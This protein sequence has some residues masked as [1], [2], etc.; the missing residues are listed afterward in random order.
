MK[1]VS[2]LLFLFITITYA[3]IHFWQSVIQVENNFFNK[4][5]IL[6]IINESNLSKTIDENQT[7]TMMDEK[8]HAFEGIIITLKNEPYSLDKNSSSF[9][10]PKSS[11]TKINQLSLRIESNRKYGYLQAV[12]R[13]KILLQ[14]L[15]I[16]QQIFKFFH[17]L[18]DNWTQLEQKSLIDYIT[19][20]RQQLKKIP[21]KDIIT[22]YK[23]VEG[24]K[25]SVAKQIQKNFFLFAREYYFFDSFLDYLTINAKL[26]T[27]H[28]IANELQLDNLINF[29]NKQ[30]TIAKINVYLRY[31]KTDLGRFILFFIIILFFWLLNYLVYKRLYNYFKARILYTEDDTDDILLDNLDKIRKPVFLLIN[32]IGIEL[33]LEVL[34]Y[35]Q[36]L[37]DKINLFFYLFF[38]IIIAYILMQLVE[39]IFFVY[40]YHRS[41][42]N[43]TLRAELLNLMLSIAKVVIFL[44]ASVVALIKLGVNITGLLASLGI[45]G[46]AV[47]LAAQTTLSNFFGLLKIIFD[48]SFSQGDWISTSSVEGTVVEIGFISTKIRTFDN[49]LIT[50]PNS[51]LANT[52]LK[53]W[54]RRTVGRR[55]KMHIG[56]TYNAQKEDLK[57]AV[58]EI[59]QMLKEHPQIVTEQKI[60]HRSLKKRYKTEGK[61]V[62]TDDKFGIKTTH[63]VYFDTFSD[64]SL[65]ILIYVF[66]KSTNWQEWLETKEDVLYKIW[67]IIEKNNLEFA[68]PSQSL[69]FDPNNIAQ[70]S[71]SLKNL[72]DKEN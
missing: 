26:L 39:N 63:L 66:T 1:K 28:S 5:N 9:F 56:V 51:E 60:D 27:Y 48:E 57:N 45:G 13:D 29:I 59:N 50:V 6:K 43:K 2:M 37:S 30:P 4:E 20:N 52:P 34:K 10:N 55:I 7:T 70:A 71:K 58:R 65:D 64:S 23:E 35:P 69:Y 40:F 21:L 14:T 12:K 53:N 22:I 42:K 17:Y 25:G 67:E 54:N 16:K 31:I 38:I 19:K 33:A 18:A 72:K 62:S 24:Q 68:F 8:F 46:L 11:E 61:F 15:Q 49:A 44:I 3:S 32:G 47:A 41:Q 36:P